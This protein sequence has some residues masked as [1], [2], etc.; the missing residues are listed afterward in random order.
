MTN[1]KALTSSDQTIS[2]NKYPQKKN[3]IKWAKFGPKE[4]KINTFTNNKLFD[5]Q[6]EYHKK[7]NTVKMK[8]PQNTEIDQTNMKR[9]NS[10]KIT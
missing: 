5:Q 7:V 1:N 3:Q 9:R 4:N 6:I 2:F 8:P 10:K